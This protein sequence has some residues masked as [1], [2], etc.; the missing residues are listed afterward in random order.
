MATS[1]GP[2]DADL[3]R[4]PAT[5]APLTPLGFLDWSA[6]VL[7]DRTAVAHGERRFTWRETRERCRRLASAL[8][9][10]GIGRGDTVAA[11]LAN[12]PELYE[13]HFAIPMTGAVL[14]VL[15]PHLDPDTLAFMLGHGE[16]K[17][18]ITDREFSPTVSRT[19][20]ALAPRPLVIDVVDPEYTG[21]GERLGDAS[22]EAVVAAGDP[23]HAWSPPADEWDAIAL[24]YTAGATADPKG[25][26]HHHRGAYLSALA[27]VLTWGIPR[28]AVYLW[29]LPM[30]DCNGWCFP[31]SIAAVGGTNVC[32]RRPDPAT[33]FRLIREHR[34]THYAGA[35]TLHDALLATPPALR[36]GIAHTVHALVVGAAPPPALIEGLERIGF[37]PSHAYGLTEAY[38]AAAVCLPRDEW[39]ELAPRERALLLGRQG[40]RRALQDAVDVLDPA[41]R[42]PVPRD[43]RTVG[44]IMIRGNSTM[45][46]YLRDPAATQH[47]LDGGW[48]HTGDLAVVHPDGHIKLHDGATDVIVSGGERISSLGVEEALHGHPAV[49]AAAVVAQPDPTLG[50]SPC[51]FVELRPG[52]AATEA[53]LTEHCRRQLTAIEVPKTI[54]LGAL[55]RTSTGKVRKHVLREVA[56]SAATV[57][58]E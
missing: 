8:A 56:R 29:T 54:V 47:A 52:A 44:E 37:A 28:G 33:V 35:P 51:A 3:A 26:V 27:N 43:G 7:P 21:P 38:G 20:A 49:A 23:E 30:F 42:R 6:D 53:E 10:R 1:T 45:K 19:L 58:A 2:L 39:R 48:L 16:A 4:T 36:E 50:Q 41:T 13:C 57:E 12:T 25:V 18:L 40:V 17:V 22:Y 9:G 14:N 32:L 31:W 11:L 24:V 55:P 46:G 15:N 5:Y 34:V